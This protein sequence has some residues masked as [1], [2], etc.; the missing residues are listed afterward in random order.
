MK[1]TTELFVKIKKAIDEKKSFM[2]YFANGGKVEDFKSQENRKVV[3]P[4][5]NKSF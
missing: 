1:I 5:G 2:K 3:R 4:D